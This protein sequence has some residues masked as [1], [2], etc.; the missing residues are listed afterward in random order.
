MRPVS[1]LIRHFAL[2]CLVY[3]V[4]LSLVHTTSVQRRLVPVLVNTV[5]WV[6]AICLPAAYLHYEPLVSDRAVPSLTGDAGMIRV[7]FGN[8]EK[9][10]EQLAAAK[11]QG[12]STASL[13]LHQ[14]DIK[15]EEFF[16]LPWLFF[17]SLT[18]VTPVPTRRKLPG[19]LVGLGLLQAFSGLKLFLYLLYNFTLFPVGIY[20][21]SGLPFRIT[22]GAFLHLKMGA[23][24]IVA[25]LVWGFLFFRATD[26]RSILHSIAMGGEGKGASKAGRGLGSDS[27]STGR[28]L[29][30]RGNR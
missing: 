12:M 29:P 5:R 14:F 19:I 15:V 28:D 8:Q 23:G 3:G 9:V 17:L 24:M 13:D 18:V 6:P 25:S 1:R 7:R 26:W 11:R 21:L 27:K 4:L 20:E 22:E 16:L 10:T 2:F 30:G